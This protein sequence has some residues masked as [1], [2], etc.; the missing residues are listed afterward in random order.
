MLIDKSKIQIDKM[1]D[2]YYRLAELIGID[3]TITLSSILSGR[4]V[5]FKKHYDLKYDYLEIIQCI[6]KTK[7][8]KLIQGFYGEYVYFSSLK[9][10]LKE[11]LHNEIRKEFSGYNS[12]ALAEKYG[13]TERAIYRIISAV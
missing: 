5:R 6:G 13:Y 3:D 4:R 8:E 12:S 11:Q 2:V 9:S 1:N 7:T 10:A